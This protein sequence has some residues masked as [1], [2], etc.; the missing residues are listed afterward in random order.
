MKSKILYA[1]L[2]V[3]M[4]M[5]FS[6]A[7]FAKGPENRDKNKN[8]IGDKKAGAVYTMTNAPDGNRVVIFDRGHNGILTIMGSVPTGGTGSGGMLDPLGSE[9][10]LVLSSDNRWLLVV[11]GGSNEISVF[12]VLP[13]GLDLTDKVNSGGFF[14]VSLTV[15]H[16]LVYVLNAGSTP[17]ITG[18]NLNHRGQLAPL[19]GSTRSLASM[20]AYAEVGFDPEGRNLVVTDKTG[21]K[22]IVYSVTDDGFPTVSPVTSVSNGM[23]PFGFIFD[24][25]GHLLIVEAGSNAVSSY[26]ILPNGTLQVISRSVPDGQKAS[27]WIVGNEDGDIFTANPGSGTFSS[28]KLMP[29][30]GQIT[31][32]DGDAG[33][34]NKPLDAA[35]AGDGRFLYALDP[36]NG[37]I[38]MFRIERD[39]GLTNL[40]AIAGD[41]ALFAQ[42]L[43]AR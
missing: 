29:Q 15:Y 23:T 13:D 35:I 18:F 20:G 42:G 32:N 3:A 41:L 31:I 21:G 34:G 30:D 36:G 14:P 7:V 1:V 40:G 43:A 12:R 8:D 2:S 17:N 5:I 38:D 27:C 11:N 26:K 28:Y 22:I 10:S 6:V 39:G 19:A 25:R 24:S 4:L 9:N 33:N 16:D 37:G